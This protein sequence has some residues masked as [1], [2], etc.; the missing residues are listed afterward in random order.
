ML[1][2]PVKTTVLAYIF[3]SSATRPSWLFA[4]LLCLTATVLVCALLCNRRLRRYT[5]QL[6]ALADQQTRIAEEALRTKSLFLANMSHEIRTPMNGITGMAALL[7]HTTLTKEQ[8]GYLDTIQSCS[9]TLL[10]VI[11]N[12]LDFSTI[13]SGKMTLDE[14]ETDLRSCVEEVLEIFMARAMMAGILL[15]C[16]IDEDVPARIIADGDRLRQV[17][18]NILGNAVKFTEKGEI[19]V[20]VFIPQQREVAS[21]GQPPAYGINAA[22]GQTPA[23][24]IDAAAAA[25]SPFPGQL[26]IGFEIKDTGIGIEPSQFDQ[27][28]QSFSQVDSSVTRKYG[29]TGLGLIISDRLVQLMNG[30]INVE[31]QPGKGSVFNFTILTRPAPLRAA[32]PGYTAIPILAEKYP[33]R[34]LLA[35]DNPINQQLALI[36]FRKM[37]YAPEVAENGKQVLDWLLRQPFDLVFMDIQMPEMDGLEAT[38]NIRAAGDQPVIIAMTAN[39]TRR[40]REE[41]LNE[42]MDDY[43]SKPVN[44]DELI[45]TLEKWGAK[46]KAASSAL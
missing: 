28:F 46:I 9:D 40:D 23:D 11:N 12:V 30:H 35:E 44:L 14:K 21:A 27:L 42:G 36:I 26:T 34:I 1:S 18:I 31:S 24:G 41:C 10:T 37:G 39:A 19:R 4:G 38:R 13:E 33:L 6:K 5:A 3:L 20:R 7:H 29:G 25:G 45:R 16:Q 8:Q 17:L 43:L 22:A 32:I 2:L 15:H